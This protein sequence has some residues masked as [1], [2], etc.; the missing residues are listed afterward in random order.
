[1][2]VSW[3]DEVDEIL[4]SDLAAGFAYLTPAKGVVITPMAP[5]G[6]R[7]REAGTVTETGIRFNVP[8]AAAERESLSS[9]GVS[10]GELLRWPGVP[11]MFTFDD[12]DGNR[13][14]ILEQTAAAAS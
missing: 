4:A 14:V 10:V 5:L 11:P 7:D 1:M 3:S 13:F 2:S 6:L 9:R 12:P 8:D